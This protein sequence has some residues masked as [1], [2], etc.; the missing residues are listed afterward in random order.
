MEAYHGLWNAVLRMWRTDRDG[1][2]LRGT[3]E[4]LL[5]L[6]PRHQPI[7]P[8]DGAPVIWIKV[9][10]GLWDKPK[11]LTFVSLL[12]VHETTAA[13]VLVV[14]PYYNRPTQ[15]GLYRHYAF[16][17]K[18]VDI[19]MILYNVPG[20]T[21]VSIAPETVARLA[22]IPNI[23]GIKEA[24]GSLDQVDQILGLCDLTVLSGED[25]LTFPMMAIGAR[26]VISVTANVVPEL[27]REMVHATLNGDLERGRELHRRLYPLSK[28]LF[29]ETNPIPVKTALGMRR[30]IRPELR[31]PLCEMGRENQAKLRQV[32]KRLEIL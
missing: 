14:T 31:L 17:A 26:G 5:G 3:E 6:L 32:L 19:P 30:L 23:V 24:S 9:D 20:R 10:A 2:L 15:E 28:T 27:V 11:F 4:V 13:G 7:L 22:R 16:L 18:K 8:P 1:F 21:G 12:K 29:V 25:S